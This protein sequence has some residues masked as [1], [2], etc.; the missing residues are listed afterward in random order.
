MRIAD[1]GWE[2]RESTTLCPCKVHT[3]CSL[4]MVYYQPQ[5]QHVC[6]EGTQNAFLGDQDPFV[7][8]G[9]NLW[10]GRTQRLYKQLQLDVDLLV[11]PC[12]TQQ[13][14]CYSTLFVSCD[15]RSWHSLMWGAYSGVLVNIGCYLDTDMCEVQASSSRAVG[16]VGWNGK[17]AAA[18]PPAG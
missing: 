18:V 3:Y 13:L 8:S 6:T 16:K 4:E 2:F 15:F 12:S 5:Y 7:D 11:F 10:P 17:H 9:A 1:L 14:L